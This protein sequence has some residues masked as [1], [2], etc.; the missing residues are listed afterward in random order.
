MLILIP[1][2]K[3]N[4]HSSSKELYPADGDHYRIH[5]WSKCRKHLELNK[6][7]YIHEEVLVNQI[8]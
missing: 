4:S 2:Y 5:N 6:T 3:C 1:T 8:I 7:W